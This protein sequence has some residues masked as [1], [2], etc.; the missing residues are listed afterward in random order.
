MSRLTDRPIHAA[1]AAALALMLSAHALADGQTRPL[2][3]PTLDQ[4]LAK[5]SDREIAVVAGGCFWGVQEVF[6]HVKGVVRATAGYAGGAPNTAHYKLV[7]TGNTGHSESVAIEYDPA[8]ISYG[9]LLKIFFAVA[10]DPMQKDRQGPDIGTQ[11]KS[12]IFALDAEQKRIADAYVS[13]LTAAHVYPRPIVTEI[14][15]LPG[16]YAAEDYHQHHAKTHPAPYILDMVAHL[17]EVFPGL[18]Q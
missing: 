8:T 11:Y 2:P 1:L 6:E 18:Y 4:P 16:F 12:R 13:Q 10:H 17:K 3:D 15:M 14:S 7:S 9:T 5:T